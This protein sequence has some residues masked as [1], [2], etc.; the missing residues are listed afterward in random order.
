M[1]ARHRDIACNRRGRK[2]SRYLDVCICAR[3]ERIVSR[4]QH[5]VA[6]ELQ[7]ESRRRQFG[8]SDSAAHGETTAGQI[9]SKSI[10]RERVLSKSEPRIEAAQRG[11]SRIRKTSYIHRHVPCSAQNGMANRTAHINIESK[12]AIELLKLR[13]KLSN[14]I[15]R[16]ARN[17]SFGRDG[18]VVRKLSG[19]RDL[20][21][22]ERYACI[23]FDWLK[24]RLFQLA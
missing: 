12:V 16:R 24:P 15:H 13:N 18:R 6:F 2:R 20:W 7:I 4:K 10:E 11:K 1:A 22:V 23:D 19:T 8:K 17:V 21:N 9:A 5:A 3:G 14:K